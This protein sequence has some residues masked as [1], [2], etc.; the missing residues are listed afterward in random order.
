MLGEWM[1]E[2][3]ASQDPDNIL[4]IQAL[5]DDESWDSIQRKYAVEGSTWYV[6]WMDG[7]GAYAKLLSEQKASLPVG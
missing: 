4:S 5:W 1:D 7:V 6:W 2:T 3:I